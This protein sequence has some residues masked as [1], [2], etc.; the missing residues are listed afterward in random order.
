MVL[1]SQV[2]AGQIV[3]L[4]DDCHELITE[5]KIQVRCSYGGG[6][7]LAVEL[8]SHGYATATNGSFT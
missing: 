6:G 8:P 7:V 5:F 3:I 1:C 4:S 2:K